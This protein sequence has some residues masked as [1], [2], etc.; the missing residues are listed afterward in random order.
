MILD[1]SMKTMETKRQEMASLKYLKKEY[2][3]PSS[4]L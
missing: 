2:K 4:L 1:L 3:S